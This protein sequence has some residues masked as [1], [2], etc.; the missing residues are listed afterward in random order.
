MSYYNKTFEGKEKAS[1]KSLF[2]DYYFK[3]TIC[4][5]LAWF[6]INFIYFGQLVVLPFIFGKAKKSFSSYAYTVL[7]EAPSFLLSI[8]LVDRPNFGRKNSLKYFFLLSSA[9]HFIFIFKPFI[10]FSSLARFFMKM[11]FQMLYPCTTESYGTLN[12]TLGFGF[13]SAIGRL[14]ATIMPYLI[15]PLI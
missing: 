7:G 15:L 14:G 3:T 11:C 12:R 13:N 1:I 5:S 9:M 4:L 8:L 10:I 2:N 6:S